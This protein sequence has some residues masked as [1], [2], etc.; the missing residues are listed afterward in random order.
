MPFRTLRTQ[1]DRHHTPTDQGV[2]TLN[3]RGFYLGRYN[4]PECRA[5]SDGL[6]AEWLTNGRTLPVAASGAGS[7]LTVNELHLRFVHWS[8]ADYRKNGE[9]TSEARM[10]RDTLKVVRRCFGDTQA[11]DFGPLALKTVRKPTSTRA[12]AVTR[13]KSGLGVSFVASDGRW[14]TSWFPPPFIMS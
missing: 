12:C 11:R 3:G 6:I 2:V 4:S 7:D 13:S 5:E 10:I 8:E 1:S 14:R 9:P